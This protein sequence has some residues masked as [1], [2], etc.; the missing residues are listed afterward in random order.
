[1]L[2]GIRISWDC[3]QDPAA[4]KESVSKLIS[5]PILES[6]SAPGSFEA[7]CPLLQAAPL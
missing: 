1:M 5:F 3:E 7:L 4:I 2:Q 6:T